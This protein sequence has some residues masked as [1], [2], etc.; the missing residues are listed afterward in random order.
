[1]LSIFR[2]IWIQIS[3]VE[4][5]KTSEQEMTTYSCVGTGQLSLTEYSI[6]VY[7]TNFQLIAQA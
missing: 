4:E 1:M 3:F 7:Y 5:Q 2:P 6:T